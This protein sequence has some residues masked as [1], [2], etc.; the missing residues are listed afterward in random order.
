MVLCTPYESKNTPKSKV[1]DNAAGI[2][3]Y[4]KFDFV[5]EGTHSDFAFRNGQ[6]VDAYAMARL[7]RT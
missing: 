1:T 7:R 5:I 4:K 3:L 6:Y 2:A